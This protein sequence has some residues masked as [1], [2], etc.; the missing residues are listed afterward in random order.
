M[1]ASLAGELAE[2]EVEGER[3]WVVAGD[4]GA[5]DAAPRGVRLLPYFDAYAVGCHPRDRVFPGPAAGRA[6]AGGQAGPFPTLLVDGTVAGVWHQRRFGRGL[7]IT[8]EPLVAL[9]AAQR[10]ALDDQAAWL[11]AFLGGIPHLTIGTVVV[12]AHA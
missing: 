1:F 7:D 12:G 11:G 4:T 8:V 9:T 10:R 3:A 5:P 6:L 2:V